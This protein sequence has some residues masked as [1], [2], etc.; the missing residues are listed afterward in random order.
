[1]PPTRT[2]TLMPEMLVVNTHPGPPSGCWKAVFRYIF[3]VSNRTRAING[4]GIAQLVSCA[5]RAERS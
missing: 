1:M 5:L 4:R 3:R 2:Y